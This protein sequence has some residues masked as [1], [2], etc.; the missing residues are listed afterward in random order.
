MHPEDADGIAIVD[1]DQTFQEQHDL[2]L[3]TYLSQCLDYLWCCFARD[4]LTRLST[5]VS[6]IFVQGRKFSNI[7]S[8]QPEH[9]LTDIV[10][11]MHSNFCLCSSKRYSS[12]QAWVE[13][14]ALL[15]PKLTS[16]CHLIHLPC[17]ENLQEHSPLERNFPVENESALSTYFGN[18]S[19]FPKIWKKNGHLEMEFQV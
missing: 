16:C 18:G 4:S 9:I 8:A 2:G 3:H 17:Q 7:P 12:W 1:P 14:Q 5:L 13:L 10:I 19:F 6:I 11:S 15:Q